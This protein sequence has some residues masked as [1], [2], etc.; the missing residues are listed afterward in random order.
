MRRVSRRWIAPPAFTLIELLVVVAII[1]ILA[2]LLLPALA[3]A[4]AKAQTVRCVSNNKQVILAFHMYVDD[5]RDS[6]PTCTDWNSAGGTNGTY[7]IYT[8]MTNRPLYSYQ[9]SPEIFHCPS[10]R[11]DIF[12]EENFGKKCTN[13]YVQYGTSYLME[14]VIDFART[15]KVTGDRLG[16]GV[17]AQS[18]K[19][20][21]VA[22]N[23]A[24]KI[25]QGDW[26]W[27]PNRGWTDPKSQWHNYKGM[28]L[29][30]IA[31][32]DGHAEIYKFPT[33]PDTNPFWSQPP[34]PLNAW[35]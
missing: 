11:G 26:T 24:N 2:G 5:N 34:N 8:A 25:I 1:A 4:R 3:K 10:D 33:I 27:H 12:Y 22:I 19:G 31:F 13:A 9:G 23:S 32:G 15:K 6:Y 18:I 30:V 29:S 7:D 20:F 28:S 17:D 14:W 35:W 16:T 21:E